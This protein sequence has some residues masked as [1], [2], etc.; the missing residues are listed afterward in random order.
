MQIQS[1][2]EEATFW[3]ETL[4]QHGHFDHLKIQDW[5]LNWIQYF[6]IDVIAV[7][8]F[9]IA[10]L[11]IGITWICKIHLCR[12]KTKKDW[13]K[14]N[15]RKYHCYLPNLRLKIHSLLLSFQRRSTTNQ[16]SKL[17]EMTENSDF[18]EHEESVF[19][20]FFPQVFEYLVQICILV[21][22]SITLCLGIYTGFVMIGIIVFLFVFFC[23][24]NP[25]VRQVLST[26]LTN[27]WSWEFFTKWVQ[28]SICSWKAFTISFL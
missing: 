17:E 4:A 11:I 10:V 1:P 14:Q 7:L 12:A 24:I 6:S 16:P 19:W 23:L 8:L 13:Q 21:I 20:C 25:W 2:K 28:P 3:I 26:M 27:I 18:R 9:L 15:K 5:H 22:V